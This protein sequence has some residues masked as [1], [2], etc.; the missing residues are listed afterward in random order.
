MPAAS[1]CCISSSTALLQLTSEPRCHAAY[2][3]LHT[4]PT[5]QRCRLAGRIC[6]HSSQT[7]PRRNETLQ[8]I[9]A[10]CNEEVEYRDSLTDIAFI[11]LCRKAYGS[12]AGGLSA[13]ANHVCTCFSNCPQQDMCTD[14]PY[15][16]SCSLVPELKALC[17]TL[18]IRDPEATEYA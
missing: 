5:P 17:P 14:A 15:D 1:C 18:A 12:L 6:A 9:N 10:V 16:K 7:P 11:A 4:L 8:S 2:L 13:T 3:A